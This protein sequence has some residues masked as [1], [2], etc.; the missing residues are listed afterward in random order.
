MSRAFFLGIFILAALAILATGVFL[1]GGKEER[2]RSTY[3]VRTKFRNVAGLIEGAPVRVGGI[4]Q[5]TVKHLWLPQKPDDDVLVAMNL[6]QE[7]RNVLKQDSVASIRSEGLLGDKFVEISFGST[8]AQPVQEGE[9]LES[10]PPLEMADLFKKASAILDS[11]KD[12]AEDLTGTANNLNNITS[13]IDQG[14]GS[15][16]KLVNDDKVYREAAAGATA[17]HENMDALKHNF[18]VRGFFRNRGYTDSA[19]LTRHAVRKLPSQQPEKEFEYDAKALFDKPD[20]A[21]LKNQKKLDEVGK[22]LEGNKYGLV[23]VAVATGPKGDSDKAQELTDARSAVVREYLAN[24]FA[25]DD[26]RIKTLGLGKSAN[27][28]EAGTLEVLVYPMGTKVPAQ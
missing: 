20:T 26:R 14:Q 23:V 12:A 15:V 11:T 27:S 25:V 4:Q 3:E 6:V 21:K 24:N 5:G 17:F 10:E 22:F 2:F 7:T 16:G 19:D 9:L 13:R 8:D 1:I 18:L 28:G